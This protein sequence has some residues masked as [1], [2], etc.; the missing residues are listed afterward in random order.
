MGQ[1]LAQVQKRRGELLERARAQ[2]SDVRAILDSQRDIFWLADR[3][4][5]LGRHILAQKSLLF[6]AGLVMVVIKPRRAL[7]WAFRGW[8]LFRWV[9]RIK[10]VLA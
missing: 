2:R 5:A 4:I 10:R 6:L 8:R 1:T 3:G 9:C 7:R